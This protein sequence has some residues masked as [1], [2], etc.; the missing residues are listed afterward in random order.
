MCHFR[1]IVVNGH[2]NFSFCQIFGWH[3]IK[4]SQKIYSRQLA[5]FSGALNSQ[6]SHTVASSKRVH[7][8][9]QVSKEGLMQ[10]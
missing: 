2:L 7:F 6:R 8:R 10:N 9:G 1:G 3:H 4:F 5:H